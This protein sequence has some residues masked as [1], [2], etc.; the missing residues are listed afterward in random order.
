MLYLTAPDP[1]LRKG[2]GPVGNKKMDQDSCFYCNQKI[3]T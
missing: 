2:W 3:F 1:L